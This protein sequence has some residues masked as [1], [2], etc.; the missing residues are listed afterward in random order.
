MQY[1]T[2]LMISKCRAKT[3]LRGFSHMECHVRFYD[4]FGNIID[5][6]MQVNHSSI[7]GTKGNSFKSRCNGRMYRSA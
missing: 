3:G 6:V 2:K 5:V 4:V 7:Q 1:R